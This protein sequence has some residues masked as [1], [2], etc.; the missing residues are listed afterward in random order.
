VSVVGLLLR[1]V[2]VA[3]RSRWRW[4]LIDE[5][6]GAPLADHAVDLDLGGAEMEA[7]ADL[8]RYLRWNADPANRVES[9]A[10]LVDR[11]GG[12][13]GAQV[14][15]SAVGSAIV[16]AAPVTVRVQL[17]PEAEFLLFLP[18]ELAHVEGAP[19][20]RR[21]DVSLVFDVGGP[22][23]VGRSAADRLRMV[24]VFSLPTETT[25]LGLR[26]ERYELA[27]MVRTLT[28]R[29]RRMVELEVLQYGVTRDSLKRRMTA[30]GGPDVLHV[31][32]HGTR[33]TVLLETVDGRPDPVD[34]GDLIGLL[35]PAAGR[36]RLAVLS[37][38]QSAAATTAETLRWLRLDAAADQAQAEADAADRAV[39]GAAPLTGLA[40]A[41]AQRFGCAVVAM[42]Y[43]VEDDFA[44]A[45]ATALYEG[46]FE[47]G[48]PVD[49]ALRRAI[50]AAAGPTASAARP[51]VSIATPT[52]L[53]PTSAGMLLT[54]PRG[55]PELVP[56]DAR[57]AT[58]LPEPERFVGRTAAMTRASQALASASPHSGV[59]FHGMAG[60]GKTA[61]A[62]E[63]A[64][65]HHTRFAIPVWW[66]APLRDEEWAG[67]LTTL[68]LALEAQL[69]GFTMVDKIGTVNGLI[70]FLPR[71]RALL[72]DNGLLL[73]LDNLETLLTPNG[74]WR[75]PRWADLMDAL[76]GHGGESRLV[77]T[78]RT[79]PA[80]LPAAMLIEPVHALS[81]DETVLLAR[82][83]PNL[84]A[85]LHAEPGPTRDAGVIDADR[86]RVRRVLHVVQGH[87][88]LLELADRAAAAPDTLA[89]HLEAAEHATTDQPLAA[90]L[91]Q[92]HSTLDSDGFLTVLA[93]W[94]ATTMHALTPDSRLLLQMLA[95]IE[96]DDRWSFVLESN[97]ADLR[98]RLQLAD[99]APD[100]TSTLGPL[101]VAALIDTETHPD[102][103]TE[104]TPP[105]RYRIHPGVA[106]TVRAATPIDIRTAIDTE[107]AAY[108]IAVIDRAK[109]PEGGE[110]TQA[111][112][113]AGLAAAP[114]LL[115]L[116]EWD[117]AASS[118][119]QALLRDITAGVAQIAVAHL[120]RIV[121]AAPQRPDFVAGLG[122]ATA[123]IDPAEGER[124]MRATL[125]QSAING[126]HRLAGAIMGDL[127]NLLSESGRLGEAL[128]L[129]DR[130]AEHTR[131]AGLG[132]WTQLADEGFRL[133][134]L[135][136]M[137]QPE[138][139]LAE[140][141]Q[142]MDQM[143]RLPNRRGA[144][145]IV[146]PFNIRET[147]HSLG[148]LAARALHRWEVALD[149]NAQNIA[150][151]RTRGAGDHDIATAQYM[152]FE[153]LLRLGHLDVC[154]ELLLT[155]QKVFEDHGDI[156]R[157]AKI[158]GQ[159]GELA[160]ARGHY[161]DAIRLEHAALRLKYTNPDPAAI[162]RSHHNLANYLRQVG[163]D[164]VG[165]LAH[166]LAAAT[167]SQMIGRGAYLVTVVQGLAR[168]ISDLPEVPPPTSIAE[169][170]GLVEQVEGV[171]FTELVT[172]LAGDPD[173][174]QQALTT[175]IQTT[176]ESPPDDVYDLQRHLDGWEPDLVTLVAAANGDPNA[177]TDIDQTLNQLAGASEWANLAAAL[178]RVVA[179]DRDPNQLTTGLDP[180]DTAIVTRALDA[181]AGHIT[182][183]PAPA[184]DTEDLWAPVI[185]ATVAAA[186][187]DQPAA[188][189]LTPLLDDMAAST[190]WANLAAALRRIIA[191]ERDPDRLLTGLDHTDTAIAA[192][193]L[194]Q[195]TTPSEERAQ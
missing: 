43:P 12:W 13:A 119:N 147:T 125:E 10:D 23:R 132:P 99:P 22:S 162:V 34:T 20:A 44:I 40:R 123:R 183:D 68:A 92:G 91:A 46:L 62:L 126:D 173:I 148:A 172:V 96:D 102:T 145:E 51:A 160:D 118:V 127:I 128:D 35:Q 141:H 180:I 53:G 90:F 80:G 149:L 77:L 153:P 87:P 146:E 100:L 42:R 113:R 47:L 143:T 171:R 107:L 1:A 155:C 157:L 193:I 67:A 175:V 55:T 186:R 115:R 129:A 139:V 179:G 30:D 48:L 167:L 56:A 161:H 14:L 28:A 52:L 138:Q 5:T 140:V 133:Q 105:L 26:R 85:L 73:V 17:P 163:A 187:G 137:G 192:T 176:R 21:G 106:E 112:V 159:R 71:L 174:A 158:L 95:G 181:L 65:G 81:R 104:D 166:R 31:S 142:L 3:G 190:D 27:R 82:E 61:C 164:P 74:E 83:L 108:W 8:Y 120:R 64:Y 103:A 188:D 54:P 60:G 97:W 184:G 168:E 111:V 29:A 59:L 84:R 86:A 41:V 114:Y 16:A 9:E 121:D 170:A 89:A 45:L 57:M 36:L 177:A 182:L 152:D 144:D 191:G 39:A 38:C 136:Q 33:G 18:L 156:H 72:R 79:P 63:L 131:Q 19:L 94:T 93:E 116:H 151:K 117:A 15:G 24:A 130:K 78:S 194:T 195:L 185:A 69:P 37:A 165:R 6:S 2:E 70:Q 135:Y 58:F 150:S 66:Q 109:Q 7:F 76:A 101:T 11:I 50:P 124:L 4:L 75:D 32:G 169:V 122:R 134:I 98:R 154:K 88:K 25:A 189:T 49:A 178:R 110:H